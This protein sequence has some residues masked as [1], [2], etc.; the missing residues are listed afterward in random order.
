MLPAPRPAP[1]TAQHRRLPDHFADKLIPFAP[2]LQASK[3]AGNDCIA[4]KSDAAKLGRVQ[5]CEDVSVTNCT[6]VSTCCAIRL[7]YEG[8]APIRNCTFSN[9]V[10]S[11]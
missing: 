8:D 2:L 5:A 7:G 6:F 4:L 10:I 3:E 11:R 1:D 9:I